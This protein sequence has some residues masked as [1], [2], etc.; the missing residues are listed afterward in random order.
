MPEI[1]PTK[2]PDNDALVLVSDG[3]TTVANMDSSSIMSSCFVDT[4]SHAIIPNSTPLKP[5]EHGMSGYAM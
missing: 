5:I 2:C 3:Y 1:A 4:S